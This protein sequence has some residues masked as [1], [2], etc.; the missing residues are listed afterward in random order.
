K[1]PLDNSA[2]HPE[3]YKVVEKMAADQGSS[4]SD[5]MERK[6]LRER[7]D[8]QQYVSEN[9]GKGGSQALG[10]PT[11]RDILEE[12]ARPG[13]DPRQEFAAFAFAD[14]V[15]SMD[16]LIEEMRLPGIVTNVTKFGAFVDIGVHQDGLVHI[17]QLADRFVKDPA[18][19]VKVGQQVTVR[20]LEVDQ[21]RKRIALS[22]REGAP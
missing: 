8:L 5:L 3:R 13:R 17:S 14:G 1:N 19:V 15:N 9:S 20:V 4:L 10:L 6:E 7:I 2:V 16:D 22:L 12:L 18:E 11:L 21:Q